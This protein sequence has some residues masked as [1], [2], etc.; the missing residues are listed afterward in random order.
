MKSASLKKIVLWIAGIIAVVLLAFT[1]SIDYIVKRGIESVGSDVTQT[2]VY[3]ED[4]SISIFTGRGTVQGISVRNPEGYESQNAIEI[5]EMTIDLDIFTLF[6]DEI[7]AEEIIVRNSSVFI[8]QKLPGNN[9]KTLMDN[10]NKATAG[11]DPSPTTMLIDYLV[12]EEASVMLSTDVGEKRSAEI[13]IS[14]FEEER[15]GYED[16]RTVRSVMK[17]VIESLAARAL[18]EGAGTLL[19]D[20]AK[21]FL[22][23]LMN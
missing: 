7:V 11:S 12:I 2:G 13:K 19:K 17:F 10:M 18:K 21:K 15:I 3:V 20:K 14:K 5:G 8:E 9:L 6:S 1:L 23:D 4:V 16:S 22:K